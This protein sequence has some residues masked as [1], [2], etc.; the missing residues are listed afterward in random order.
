MS[1]GMARAAASPPRT[2]WLQQQHLRQP[3]LQQPTAST[4]TEIEAE[5]VYWDVGECFYFL[6]LVCP[7]DILCCKLVHL[8]SSPACPRQDSWGGHIE[9]LTM[10]IHI[11]IGRN[12]KNSATTTVGRHLCSVGMYVQ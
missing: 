3:H 1:A 11:S 5:L 12:K 7:L 8:I 10:T 2:L 6:S 9:V 4:R